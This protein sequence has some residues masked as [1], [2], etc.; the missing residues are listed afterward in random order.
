MACA[1]CVATMAALIKSMILRHPAWQ[2]SAMQR[3]LPCRKF[4][5]R[6]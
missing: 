4:T 3:A 2:A 6:L 5:N 1:W